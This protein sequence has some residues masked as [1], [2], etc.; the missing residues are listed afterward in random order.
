MLSI[1]AGAIGAII[2]IF[3]Q[4]AAIVIAGFTA[5]GYIVLNL[6]DQFTGFP[7]QMVWLPY[8]I[9]GVVG[10]IVL[11]LVFDWASLEQMVL[12]LTGIDITTCPCCNQGKMKMLAEIPM[13]R[14]RAPNY[15]TT[16]IR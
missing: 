15:L 14:A 7:A 5:G 9:G 13:Y 11:F 2:A 10:A 16:A 1:V 8:L 4:K 3:F 6:L 12:Q